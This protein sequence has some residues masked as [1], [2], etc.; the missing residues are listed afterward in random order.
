MPPGRW[1]CVLCG[2]RMGPYR[3]ICCGRRACLKCP[4]DCLRA[5]MWMKE[6]RKM[7]PKSKTARVRLP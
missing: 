6:D 3:T 1:I 2:K 7:R 4:C 5:Q